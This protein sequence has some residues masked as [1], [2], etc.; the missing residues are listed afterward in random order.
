MRDE[1]FIEN[2]ED[3]AMEMPVIVGFM[4]VLPSTNTRHVLRL[5]L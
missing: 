1:E 2:L 5:F 4:V 3:L